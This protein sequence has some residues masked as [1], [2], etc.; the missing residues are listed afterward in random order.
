VAGGGGLKS[1]P[2]LPDSAA[3]SSGYRGIFAAAVLVSLFVANH[4]F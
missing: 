2:G 1:V 3:A 4:V